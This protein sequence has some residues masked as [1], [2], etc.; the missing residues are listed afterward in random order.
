MVLNTRF[1]LEDALK[2]IKTSEEQPHVK[3]AIEILE[4]CCEKFS[5][6]EIFLSFNGG[7]DCTT[8]LHLAACVFKLKKVS[9]LLCLYVTEDPF[10][11]VDAF[12]EEAASYY[13]LELVKKKKPI[14]SALMALQ[15]ERRMI[16]ASLMGTRRGDPGSDKLESF[17][18][19]DSGWPNLTRIFPILD[20]SYKQIWQFL[21]D[22]KVPYCSLYDQG[23][24]SLGS[25]STTAPNPVLRRSEGSY[26]PA[27]M[28]SDDST[29]RNGRR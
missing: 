22:H 10:P 6:T 14:K 27:H 17:T 1:T 12:V 25:R 23:Y 15:N 24:T 28:L 11:E 7:K 26:L 29:E 20:W 18:P 2:V 9:P 8:V 16:K 3:S 19:T 5:N 21:L 13:E 4:Q